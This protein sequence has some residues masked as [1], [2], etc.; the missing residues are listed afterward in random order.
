MSPPGHDDDMLELCPAPYVVDFAFDVRLHAAARLRGE[1]RQ[2]A[3]FHRTSI[4]ARERVRLQRM[5]QVS[6]PSRWVTMV[7]W[8]HQT[9]AH[10]LVVGH[11]LWAYG[12]VHPFW[13]C[14][15]RFSLIAS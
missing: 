14:C 13:A 8:C 2:V 11:H 10:G 7:A 9:T 6:L 1:K 12:R 15:L 4:P 3:D 5:I